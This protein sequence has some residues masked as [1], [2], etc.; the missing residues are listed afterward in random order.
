L[1]FKTD[2]FDLVWNS[3]VMEHFTERALI[4]GLT[5]MAR[6]SRRYV[7]VFVPFK[8][9]LPYNLAKLISEAEGTWEWGLERPKR[10]LKDEFF[11]AG[12]DVIDEYEFGHETNIPLSYMRLLPDHIADELTRDYY[13]RGQFYPGVFLVTI[14]VKK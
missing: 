2:T 4:L 12:I 7:A 14:G 9:C 8:D 5:E 3:G 10:T 11:K 13:N 6:V 1:P